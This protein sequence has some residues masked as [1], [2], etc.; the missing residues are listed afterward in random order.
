MV[1]CMCVG[2]RGSREPAG[3]SEAPGE[4]DVTHT[5]TRVLEWMTTS[6]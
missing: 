2:R 1:V 5:H 4:A 6:H 3:G